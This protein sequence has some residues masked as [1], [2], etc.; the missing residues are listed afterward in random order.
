MLS[1]L[2][3][4]KIHAVRVAIFLAW[5][6]LIVSL[7]YDPITAIFTQPEH[8]WSWLSDQNI[9]RAND[10]TRCVQLQGSCIP[11]SSYPIGTRVFWG[12]VIPSAIFMVLVL[13]H[14]FWRRLCPLYFFSQLPRALQM[15]PLLNIEQ[16]NWLKRNHL[17]VQF[18]LFYLGITAR[19]L[20]TNALR[21]ATGILFV[22]TLLSA[23]SMVVLYGGRSW[24]HYV[25]PFGMVQMVFTGPK[26]LLASQAH[27]AKPYSMTQSM[28]RTVDEQGNEESACVSCK[29]SCM[30][31]DAEQ[32]YW[33]QLHKPGRKL[34]QYGYLGLVLGYVSYY[35]LYAGNVTYYFSG[36]WS[37][38]P[39]RASSLFGPG[40][41]LFGSP[42]PVPKLLAAPLTLAGFAIASYILCTAIERYYRGMLKQKDPTATAEKSL[43][44]MFSVCT[45]VAFN[46]FFIYGGRPEINKLPIAVQFAFQAMIAVVSSLWLYQSW[47]RSAELYQQESVA[48]KQRRM[49]RKLAVN[50]DDLLQEKSLQQLDAKEIGLLAK[51]LPRLAKNSGA[52]ESETSVANGAL[53]TVHK[54]PRTALRSNRSA[55]NNLAINN[56]QQA[57]IVPPLAIPKTHIRKLP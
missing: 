8:T 55:I 19:I 6:L 36:V 18:I 11:L 3:E 56:T 57:A 40:F 50:V 42:V 16:N 9:S 2:S 32:S 30:D 41:Y 31:I 37:Y 1:T 25:C 38:E 28:C 7:F 20:L 13:G 44:R 23:V 29:S 45:F 27:T 10:L 43:H 46:I 39:W 22:V 33:A 21:P 12:M 5:C 52:H 51:I 34:V 24:C 48:D 35:W 14:E 53:P 47:G 4:K 15:K 26:G 54:L 17:Y 49:V